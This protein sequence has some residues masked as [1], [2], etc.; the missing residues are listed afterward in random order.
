MCV[1]VWK[2]VQ[3]TVNTSWYLCGTPLASTEAKASLPVYNYKIIPLPA[4]CMCMC[5][6]DIC[7]WPLTSS[8]SFREV[9]VA[10]VWASPAFL[11]C[12][13]DWKQ[14]REKASVINSHREITNKVKREEKGDI[15][16]KTFKISSLCEAGL[17]QLWGSWKLLFEHTHLETCHTRLLYSLFAKHS[18]VFDELHLWD[19]SLNVI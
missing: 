3:L 10:N 12:I 9:R 15:S 16:V 8:S 19:T 14:E 5:V 6:C 1:C 17:F 7:I 2:S 11:D 4:L 18:H 13:I